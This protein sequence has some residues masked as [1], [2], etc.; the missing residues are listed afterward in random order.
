V[1]LV[2]V[3]TDGE[4]QRVAFAAADP[5]VERLLRHLPAAYP[6]DEEP[7]DPIVRVVRTG[8]TETLA[9][10]PAGGVFGRWSG[11][12]GER[13]LQS[14]MLIPL[15]ARGRTIG[16]LALASLD[17]SRA[18]GDEELTLAED[19]A[20]RAALA[21][22]NA[23]L[24]EQQSAVARVLQESLLPER[25]PHL[26]A[27]ELG[28]AYRPAGDGT[29]I[30]G[31]FYDAF[32][33]PDGGIALA[34]GDVTG[35]GAKAAALTGLTRHTL[36]TAAMYER[37][38]SAILG[39]LNRALL[40]QRNRRG[41]YCTVALA[42]LEPAN[43]HVNAYVACAGHPLPLVLRADGSVE[44]VGHPGTVLGFVDDPRLHDAPTQLRRG[45]ALVL[46]TDGITEARTRTGLLGDERFAGLVRACAGLDAGAIASR[47]ERAAIESQQGRPRDDVAIA[48]ARV[49]D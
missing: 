29:E 5:V 40:A 12:L 24:F 22:D 25:L 1:C 43:A 46:Y 36:R 14:A 34:I 17:P 45:D 35:K 27:V 16:V 33:A 7:D 48:V 20:R 2:D 23:R 39:T 30:G 11:V 3:L 13:T 18:F 26:D 15:K 6:V 9:A 10:G 41:K 28:A 19:L 4:V 32:P 49:R 8:R 47:L 44:T 37:Q 21:V 38:P 42:R 31:D